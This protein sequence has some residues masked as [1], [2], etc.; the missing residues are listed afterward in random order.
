MTFDSGEDETTVLNGFTI[1]NGMAFPGYF[2]SGPFAGGVGGGIICDGAS[3][4]L[5]NLIIKNNATPSGSNYGGGIF[6]KAG[7]ISIENC[8][9]KNNTSDNGSGI[10]IYGGSGGSS[11]S[12]KKFCYL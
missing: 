3:P 11:G 9:V 10:W 6:A 1:Q 5:K 12:I 8:V 2:D 4:V 7:N